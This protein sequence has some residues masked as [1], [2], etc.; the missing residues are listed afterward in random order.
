MSRR[1]GGKTQAQLDA[2]SRSLN[3]RDVVGHA[4]FTNETA[5]RTLGTP[6]Y[7]AVQDNRRSQMAEP[8][9][10]ARPK[11]DSPSASQEDSPSG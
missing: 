8:S 7:R 4:A 5:Q 10:R 6:A 3:R 1:S 11:A 9:V 2:R